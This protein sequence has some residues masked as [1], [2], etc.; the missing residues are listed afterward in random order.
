MKLL[1]NVFNWT[2]QDQYHT[3]QS[4]A[5]G[6][7]WAFNSNNLL[8]LFESLITFGFEMSSGQLSLQEQELYFECIGRKRTGEHLTR[9][10]FPKLK[11]ERAI[12]RIGRWIKNV[13]RQD[14]GEIPKE[15]DHIIPAGF[16]CMDETKIKITATFRAL[17]YTGDIE[18]NMKLHE[19]IQRFNLKYVGELFPYIA[20]PCFAIL[21]TDIELED[22][23][24]L[25]RATT[26]F[27]YN[28][29]LGIIEFPDINLAIVRKGPGAIEMVKLE[30]LI[31][32]KD[33]RM[34]LLSEGW[35]AQS[36]R[37]KY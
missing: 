1:R 18:H 4:L 30:E 37:I 36:L 14:L 3:N 34:R 15:S 8:N 20:G 23:S 17:G 29:S 25:P 9:E 26:S 27:F 12:A 6:L 21:N 16:L 31:D 24:L 35:V 28:R 7:Q 19:F 10:D 13:S 22:V 2:K 32:T 5:Y 11:N 33:I